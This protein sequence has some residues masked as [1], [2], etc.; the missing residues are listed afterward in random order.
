[1]KSLI[2][3]SIWIIISRDRD[4]AIEKDMA[5]TNHIGPGVYVEM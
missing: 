4:L 5:L 1:M 2:E 3:Q